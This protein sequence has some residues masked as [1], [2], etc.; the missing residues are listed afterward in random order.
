[1]GVNCVCHLLF[2][3]NQKIKQLLRKMASFTVSITGTGPFS[4]FWYKNGEFYSNE[5]DTY[6]QTN[7]LITPPLSAINNGDYYNC[8]MNNCAHTK[9]AQSNMATV[10]VTAII[11]NT[12]DFYIKNASLSTTT[13][14][15]G[16]I[17]G[18]YCEQCYSGSSQIQTWEMCLLAIICQVLQVSTLPP[19]FC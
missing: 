8:L 12:E 6:S 4:Y 17:V 3:P 16:G 14:E 9:Q 5:L 7:T 13:A 1:M 18:V 10:T 2:L 11:P 19:Q 15:P